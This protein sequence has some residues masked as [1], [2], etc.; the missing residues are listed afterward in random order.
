MKVLSR[1]TVAS[2]L[3]SLGLLGHA[4]HASA[5]FIV[6]DPLSMAKAVTEYAEQANRWKA[7]LE[8]YQQTVQHYQQMIASVTS[9]S[10]SS[11]LP[12]NSRLQKITDAPTVIQQACPGV[13]G[14]DGVVDTLL[15]G[16]DAAS[17]I[18]QVSQ[19]LCQQAAQVRI[20]KYNDSVDMLERMQAYNGQMQ[21]IDALRNALGGSSAIGDLQ[22]NTN[23]ATRTANK[24]QAELNFWRLK[25]AA[26]DSAISE[27]TSRQSDLVRLSM[28]GS[29]GTAG[30]LIGN[31]VQAGAF[32]AAFK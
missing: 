18:R 20:D 27:L 25:M 5:Q 8:Q 17:P 11:V 2:A 7:T 24:M 6:N 32:A 26:Y 31:A 13:G 28:R 22:A 9:L 3:L 14:F 15:G 1:E 4:G 29:A 30:N 19:N 23:E 12:R 16:S 21:Q 10:F